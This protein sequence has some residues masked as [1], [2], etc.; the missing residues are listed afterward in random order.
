M[1]LS[2]V[3]YDTLIAMDYINDIMSPLVNSLATWLGHFV[4]PCFWTEM[5]HTYKYTI[6]VA[7]ALLEGEMVLI[8]SGA[9]AY[10]GYM[11][12]PLVMVIAFLGALLHDAFLFFVGRFFGQ[13]ILHGQY[14]G[15]RGI[16]KIVNLIQKHDRYFIM[17]FRFIY[18]IRTL[19][20]IVVGAGSITFKRYF[21]LVAIS[22]ALWAIIVS[23]VGYS[24]AMALENII[25]HFE[26]IQKY[27]AGGLVILIGGVYL[28]FKYRKKK[29]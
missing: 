4:S 13:K 24:C 11:S 16:T 15:Q 5:L 8:L 3:F 1:L 10:H 23:Y 9:A 6:V 27:L 21:S 14:R 12:L 17:S 22:A 20:P 25:E 7:G 2:F 29:P 26:K 19:T 28:Y 18:G